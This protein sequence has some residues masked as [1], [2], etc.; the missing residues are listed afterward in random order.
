MLGNF[1]FG[2][3]FKKEAIAFAWKFLTEILKIPTEKLWVTVYQDD[4]ESEDIWLNEI[5]VDPARFSRCGEADNFWSMGDTGPCGPCTEIFYDHGPEVEGGPPGSPDQEGDRYVEIW[6]LVFMQYNR[7]TEGNMKPLPK[8][9]VDTGMGLERIAAVMQGVHD[10]YDIDLFQLLLK[11]LSELVD[12]DDFSEPSMRVIVDHIRS[13]GFLI[14]DGVT[15]SN[16]GRGYVLRRIIRRA[17]RHGYNLGQKDVFFYKLVQPLASIMGDAYP[18]LRKSQ[19]LIEQVIEQEEIQFANTLSKGLKIF[20]QATAKLKGEQIPGQIVFQLYDTY[21]FPPD[22]TADIARERGLTLDYPGFET[23]MEKQRE[24]SQQ[25]NPFSVDYTEQLYIVGDTEFIGYETLSGESKVTTLLQNN[26]PVKKLEGTQ[27][28]V[29]VLDR[30]PFYAESGGQVGDSGYLY[31]DS[32]SFRVRDTKKKVKA[33]LHYG[34][35]VKGTLN[36]ED[37]VQAEVDPSRQ[38]IVLNHSATHLLHEAL[39]RVLGEHVTQKGSLVE[40]RRLRFDFSNP[41]PLTEAQLQAVERLVN[42]QIRANFATQKETKSLEE[43]K[44]GGAMALFGEK[45]GNE[46]FVV[47]MGDFS[48]EICG[49]THVHHTG[50]IG[51]FKI[52][53]ETACA[54]GIRRIEAVTGNEA[55]LWIERGEEQLDA[56][57]SILKTNRDEV[58]TKVNQALQQSRNLS[59]ELTRLKQQLAHQQSGNLS[60]QAIDIEGI[61]V[62]AI[63]MESVDRETLR[64]TLDKL[65]QELGT[66]AIV[67]AAVKNEDVQLVAGVSKNC[68]EHFNATELLNSVAHR[69][70]GKGG[71]RPDLAQ[72]GG[73]NPKELES[74]LGGVVDWVR[75][76]LK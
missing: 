48:T 54:A 60:D 13:V 10:N 59:K 75:M 63:E 25:A 73:D 20:E 6:N 14:M 68:L 31:F 16:E 42:Q 4:K 27:T 67:L 57:A 37:K 69:V 36:V 32:G 11:S 45:Y 9:C 55:L 23:A 18:Q 47:S 53:S 28:G 22:L 19:P 17:I 74:A 1:S 61:K 21:G 15:P 65:K 24:Q 30:T 41:K 34:E 50:E 52:T 62:L 43:A 40:A 35:M 56:L 71:G 33:I 2:D 58:L 70:G 49:G 38:A 44:K 12:C 76:K 66:Y 29:V 26:K 46:V 51:I 8:P 5:K 72:G 64:N 7:D 39:R 3:Y